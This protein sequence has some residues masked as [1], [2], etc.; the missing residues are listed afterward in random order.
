MFISILLALSFHALTFLVVQNFLPLV[1]EDIPDY[2]GPI[3]VTISRPESTRARIDT[4][5]TTQ[6]GAKKKET[7]SQESEQV[8]QKSDRTELTKD[9][10]TPRIESG[11]KATLL[12]SREEK[13]KTEAK[14][15]QEGLVE[16]AIPEADAYVPVEQEGT[17]P[18][19][20][21]RA[22]VEETGGDEV[23]TFESTAE[24]DEGPLA[25]DIGKLDKAIEK[26][27]ETPP[28]E[29]EG[30]ATQEAGGTAEV[31]S[32]AG[33]PLIIWDDASSKRSLVFSGPSPKIPSWVKREGLDLKVS[34]SFAVTAEG[35]TTS[36]M[37]DES[38]GYSDVDAAVLDAVRKMKFEAAPGSD[39][40]SG[41]IKYIISTK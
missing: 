34:V 17:V 22:F 13:V 21:K 9:R 30:T 4:P 14:E 33:G 23:K 38:S 25:F 1:P 29:R 41:I 5:V 28:D 18:P 16:K 35:L 3:I 32:S 6:K 12:E 2:S 19:V 10:E 8:V 26:Q 15:E 7:I 31:V 11:Q 40:V 27:K 24:V 20:Q 36:V 39:N 37:I